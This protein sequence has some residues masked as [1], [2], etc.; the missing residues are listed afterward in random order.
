M[1]PNSD[2]RQMF[3]L[4]HRTRAA[5]KRDFKM[6]HLVFRLE[7]HGKRGVKKITLITTGH[8]TI[9]R[10]PVIYDRIVSRMVFEKSHPPLTGL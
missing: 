9:V 6:L 1:F 5:V 10:R 3:S 4:I 2:Y 7:Q 8:E